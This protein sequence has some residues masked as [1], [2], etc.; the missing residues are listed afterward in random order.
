MSSELL[1]LLEQEAQSER[2][3]ALGEARARA[4][5]IVASA[6]QEAEAIRAEHR[7]RA[8][9]ERTQIRTQAASAASLRAAALLLQAKDEAIQAVFAR[10]TDELKR[11]SEDPARRRKLLRHLIE[12]AAEG[13]P[14]NRAILEVAPGDAAPAKAVCRELGLAVEVRETPEASGGIRLTTE[15]RRITIENTVAS[16]LS[17]T[18]SSLVSRVAETLWGQ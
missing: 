2:D 11:V 6:R 12:E 7:R 18:R 16:R 1:R 3:K 10:A 13:L 4:E 15:D 17:R 8:E 5:Q 9:G 14:A